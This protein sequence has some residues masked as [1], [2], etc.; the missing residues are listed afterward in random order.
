MRREATMRRFNFPR[1]SHKPKLRAVLL[2]ELITRA[3][4]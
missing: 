2:I 4:L 1:A 3:V